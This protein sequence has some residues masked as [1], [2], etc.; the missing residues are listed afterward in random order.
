MTLEE[1]SERTT[2]MLRGKVVRRILR[3]RD[4]EVVIEFKDGSRFFADSDSPLELSVTLA[5]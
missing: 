4:G 5:E 3:H 2:S 1:E